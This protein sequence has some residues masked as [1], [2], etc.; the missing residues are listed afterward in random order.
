MAMSPARRRTVLTLAA[1]LATLAASYYV[2]DPEIAR[3]T[4]SAAVVLAWVCAWDFWVTGPLT[5]R[6]WLDRVIF[7]GTALGVACLAWLFLGRVHS[8]VEDRPV[9]SI[10]MDEEY[11]HYFLRVRNGGAWA[12]FSAQIEFAEPPWEQNPR[13]RFPGYWEEG[14]GRQSEIASGFEDRLHIAGIESG[15][16]L[17]VYVTQPGSEDL[18]RLGMNPKHPP[19]DLGAHKIAFK[20]V[21]SSNPAMEV[22]PL[23]HTYQLSLEGLKKIPEN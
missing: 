15:P 17:T 21:I 3:L 12:V 6:R 7:G 20:V 11:G 2:T 1:A 10:S 14:R 19:F 23:V 9:A 18:L 5:R 13:T 8:A 4:G 16:V 22:D